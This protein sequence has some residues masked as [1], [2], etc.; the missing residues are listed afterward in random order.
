MQS[1]VLRFGLFVVGLALLATVAFGDDHQPPGHS[2]NELK[3]PKDNETNVELSHNP[4]DDAYAYIKNNSGE[5]ARYIQIELKKTDGDDEDVL[6]DFHAHRLTVNGVIVEQAS[7][8][9]KQ[10]LDPQQPEEERQALVAGERGLRGGEKEKETVCIA[11]TQFIS[12]CEVVE[13]DLKLEIREQ[14]PGEF[15]ETQE[16]PLHFNIRLKDS[17]A[18]VIPP[19]EN[20]EKL[21]EA[22]PGGPDGQKYSDAFEAWEIELEPISVD[23]AETPG[24]VPAPDL[25]HGELTSRF[26]A[27]VLE[28]VPLADAAFEIDFP[29]VLAID[30]NGELVDDAER[31]EFGDVS[32][33]NG[34]AQVDI[35]HRDPDDPTPLAIVVRDL[36][37]NVP[38]LTA[39]QV[40]GYSSGGNATHGSRY[41]V[42]RLV[43]TGTPSGAVEFSRA[44]GD[45]G[46]PPLNLGPAPY[47]VRHFDGEP[48]NGYT[49]GIVLEE[50]APGLFS[51]GSIVYRPLDAF[52]IVSDEE[53]HVYMLDAETD[54]DL[55]DAFDGVSVSSMPDGGAKLTL[56]QRSTPSRLKIVVANLK[57]DLGTAPFDYRDNARLGV[58]GNAM[59]GVAPRSFVLAEGAPMR[60]GDEPRILRLEPIEGIPWTEVAGF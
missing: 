1:N 8:E 32:L 2:G 24:V 33:I 22:D 14:P 5:S 16:T 10:I 37:I 40:L 58:G 11:L 50:S 43:T 26:R 60:D 35:L 59:P 19:E 38:Q 18:A 3:L 28:F 42:A 44:I 39:D 36:M 9:K 4:M 23:P 52:D 41:S 12:D 46:D 30:R 57:L 25:V 48:V 21:P 27:G 53:T 34:R 51:S 15:A 6:D 20:G 7:G 13:L 56:G 55:P 49:E 29:E 45:D 17:N 31:I 47:I 54:E